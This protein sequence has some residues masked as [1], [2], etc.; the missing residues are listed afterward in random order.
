[1][2]FGEDMAA[3]WTKDLYAPWIV[4]RLHGHVPPL[5][6]RIL[7][8]RGR[9]QFPCCSAGPSHCGLFPFGQKVVSRARQLWPELARPGLRA[10]EIIALQHEDCNWDDGQ[11]RVRS[12]SGRE[13]LLPISADVGAAIAAY[14]QQGR[15]TS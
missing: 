4:F 6:H 11:V 8:D 15:P 2:A 9:L 1:M 3:V 13:Q 5:A 12:K 10:H 14:P 7:N